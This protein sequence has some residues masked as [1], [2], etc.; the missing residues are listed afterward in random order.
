MPHEILFDVIL[1]TYAP[2]N[3]KYSGSSLEECIP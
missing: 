3:D 1:C 2:I